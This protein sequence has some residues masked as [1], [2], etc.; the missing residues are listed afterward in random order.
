MVNAVGDCWLRW[1]LTPFT[2]IQALFT[3]IAKLLFHQSLCCTL[4]TGW[5]PNGNVVTVKQW[6]QWLHHHQVVTMKPHCS[7]VTDGI[8]ILLCKWCFSLYSRL[9]FAAAVDLILI[10][11]P[12]YMRKLTHD[13]HN[14]VRLCND[15]KNRTWQ[16]RSHS[17]LYDTCWSMT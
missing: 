4:T 3:Y 13:N 5:L 17:N 15:D 6:W 12:V 8:G 9:S 7:I 16:V 2:Y 1:D 10:R 11:Y 14:I